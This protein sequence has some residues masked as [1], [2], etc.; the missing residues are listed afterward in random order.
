MEEHEN[1][2]GKDDRAKES[3]HSKQVPRQQKKKSFYI[4]QT[5][6][7]DFREF[8]SFFEYKYDF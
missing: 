5:I 1:C 2:N 6:E 8:Y 3:E 7:E 4:K